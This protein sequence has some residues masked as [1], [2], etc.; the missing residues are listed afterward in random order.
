V[1][2]ES[3]SQATSADDFLSSEDKAL[4]RFR[5]VCAL[6]EANKADLKILRE[7]LERKHGGHFF[8]KGYEADIWSEVHE[9]DLVSL[10]AGSRN[11]D[12]L[13][14]WVDLYI[15]PFYHQVLGHRVKVSTNVSYRPPGPESVRASSSATLI[16]L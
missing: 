7:W 5:K 8:L 16:G 2:H 10:T 6:E 13:S 11:K 1:E 12:T 15:L 9:K 3:R 4:L 14:H